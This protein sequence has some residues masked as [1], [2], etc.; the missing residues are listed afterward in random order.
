MKDGSSGKPPDQTGKR[1]RNK[2]QAFLTFCESRKNGLTISSS[3]KA[4]GIS[5][6]TATRYESL[7]IADIERENGLLD[8][9][10]RIATKNRLAEK[11]TTALDQA[12]TQYIAGIAGA[13]SR[14]MGYDAPSRSQVEVRS[15]P[16]SVESW[17]QTCLT[18][19]VEAESKQLQEHDPPKA[20]TD[21]AS[22]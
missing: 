13:L 6:P 4:S 15:V 11:L 21:K 7:R 14:V 1:W 18:I 19:D 2:P 16:A 8:A 22:T 3:A 5:R 10:G 17:M 9:E 20:L 12:E